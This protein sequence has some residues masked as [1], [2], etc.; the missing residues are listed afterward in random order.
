M[1]VGALC[2]RTLA[3][4][5]GVGLELLLE[6]RE[7]GK[8]RIGIGR[9]VAALP[10]FA[11]TFEVFGTQLGVTIRAIATPGPI[12][13]P[14]A[15]RTVTPVGT[16]L[17]GAAILIVAILIGTNL[18]RTALIRT[19]LI[20][21]RMI[22]TAL[23]MPARPALLPHIRPIRDRSGAR[24]GLTGRRRGRR[25]GGQL[26]AC[27]VFSAWMRRR[28]GARRPPMAPGTFLAPQPPNLDELRFLGHLGRSRW[29]RLGGCRLVRRRRICLQKDRFCRHRLR[30]FRIG[31][32]HQGRRRVRVQ[33]RRGC[34][35]GSQVGSRICNR[36][37]N[38]RDRSSRFGA[39]CGHGFGC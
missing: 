1:A 20:R 21:T 6:R 9:L 11:T 39:G 13:A 31:R 30:H 12:R 2:Q 4:L 32:N 18:I 38:Q 5:L 7:L 34:R 36:L 26:G 28:A 10:V 25:L 8:G 24:H 27:A 16:I 17:T 35:V 3:P 22:R 23:A 14:V 33:R 37:G 29:L 15:L 19:C